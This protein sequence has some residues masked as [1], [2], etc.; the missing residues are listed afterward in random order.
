MSKI[1]AVTGATGFVGKH[2]VRHLAARGYTV[3]ALTRKPQPSLESVDWIEG[4]F[5]DS[6][7]L[8]KLVAGA[9]VIFHIAGAIKARN[10]QEFAAINRDSVSALLDA[11][12]AKRPKPH[13]V[14]LSSLAARERHLSPYAESKRQGEEILFDHAPQDLN[15]SIIRAP[16]VYGPGDY[17]ILKLFKSLKWGFS[18]VPGSRNN[19]TSLIFVEDLVTAMT[20]C[21]NCENVFFKILD[22]DD[23][24]E[25]GYSLQEIFATASEIM[26]RRAVKLTAGR[27]SLKLFAHT[28][29]FMSRIFGYVPMV[30][31]EKVNELCHPDWR[32]RDEHIKNFI[33]WEPKIRLNKGL[34]ICFRWYREENLL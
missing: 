18:L 1:A 23:S 5:H 34:E 12:P 25:G 26:N 22:V 32:C 4:G 16:A 21:A 17:E 19:R 6:D 20:E 2:M 33:A 30:S 24:T 13:F 28:N 10:F 31:P 14:L 3:R 7:A 9:D 8:T 15:W 29:K 11:I 27:K